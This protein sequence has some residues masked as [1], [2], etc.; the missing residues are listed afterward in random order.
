[1]EQTTDYWMCGGGFLLVGDRLTASIQVVTRWQS[2]FTIH[3]SQSQSPI[4]KMTIT[5]VGV[6]V[7]SSSDN[8]IIATIPAFQDDL[9]GSR[10]LVLWKYVLRSE[11]TS[12]NKYMTRLLYISV[13]LRTR[14]DTISYSFIYIVQK[15]WNWGLG[16]WGLGNCESGDYETGKLGN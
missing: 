4:T 11:S 6:G 16:N 15:L 3:Q 8:T 14:R 10:L 7:Y 5:T 2:P 12:W 9:R 13:C 1:M